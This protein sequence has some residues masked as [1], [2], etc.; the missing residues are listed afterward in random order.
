MP[1]KRATEC[2]DK[3]GR[4]LKVGDEVIVRGKVTALPM[5]LEDGGK[6]IASVAWRGAI[7]LSNLVESG[8]LEKSVLK[9]VKT[10][11]RKRATSKSTGEPDRG[12]GGGH[13]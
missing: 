10:P 3:H 9:L 4:T 8:E 1:I 12:I 6:A 2:K 13:K 11:A 5:D 7:P